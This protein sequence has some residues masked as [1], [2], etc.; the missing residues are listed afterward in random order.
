[1]IPTLGEM[2]TSETKLASRVDEIEINKQ[3]IKSIFEQETPVPVV[4]EEA[5]VAAP[6]VKEAAKIVEEPAPGATEE[7]TTLEVAAA[8]EAAP[9]TPVVEEVAAAPETA[10]AGVNTRHDQ[11]LLA[12]IRS[13]WD[14]TPLQQ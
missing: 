8:P 5:P 1:M 4:A 2:A 12:R 3:A 13:G 14:Q 6:V 7:A 9:E 10:I 11:V